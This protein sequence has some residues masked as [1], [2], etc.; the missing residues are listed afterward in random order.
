MEQRLYGIRGAT[1]CTNTVEDIEVQVRLLYD[2]LLSLNDLQESDI[3]SI[4]FTITR[5]LTACNPAA[6]LRKQGKAQ[7]CALFVCQEPHTDEALPGIIR[8]LIHGYLPAGKKV[9]H[10]YRNGAEL[11]RPDWASIP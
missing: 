1:G 8:I 11:L 2:G 9:R 3:V 5:D 7:E 10:L 4:F 6:A